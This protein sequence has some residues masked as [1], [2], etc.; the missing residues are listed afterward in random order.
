MNPTKT[1]GWTGVEM[2]TPQKTNMDTQHACLEKNSPFKEHYLYQ[3]SG[4]Y[5]MTQT[6]I[7]TYNLP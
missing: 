3:I 7:S 4:L 1:A 2:N 6:R 5:T